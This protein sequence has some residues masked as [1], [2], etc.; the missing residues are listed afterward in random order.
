MSIRRVGQRLAVVVGVTMVMATISFGQNGAAQDLGDC[1]LKPLTLP[2]FDA[3]PVAVVAA[4]PV[5][6]EMAPAVDELAIADAMETIVT[7]ANSAN[8]AEANSIFTERY[9]A[10]LFLDPTTYLPALEQELDSP[11]TQVTGT[12]ELDE[13]ISVTVLA[14]GRTEVVAKLHNSSASFTDTFVLA[15]V[16]G[17]WLID[18]V[19]NL[20]PQP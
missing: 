15:Y 18:D 5:S 13:I 20:D 2:L 14:D 8:L 9:L 10:S 11:S 4:T 7:C 19:T 12:L 16:D 17:A 6:M 3:A 1:A